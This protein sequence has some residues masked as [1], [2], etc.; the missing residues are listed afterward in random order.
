MKK[1]KSTIFT[2]EEVEWI[3]KNHKGI[4][5]DDLT[6]IINK[7]FNK[8]ITRQQLKGFRSNHSLPS[9]VDTTFKKGVVSYRPPKGVRNSI[10]TE[11]KKGNKPHN[12]ALIGSEVVKK[13]YWYRKIKDDSPVGQSRRNWKLIH[14]LVWEEYNGEIPKGNRIIFLDGNTSN[15][16]IKNLALISGAEAAVMSKQNLFSNNQEITKTGNLIAKNIIAINKKLK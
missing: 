7:K 14:H 11:F 13:G 8:N 1:I 2:Q 15:F 4:G 10:K 16:D 12:T 3:V 6:E 9:G 5:T